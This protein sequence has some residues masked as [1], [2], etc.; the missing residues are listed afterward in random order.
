MLVFQQAGKSDPVAPLLEVNAGEIGFM[1]PP[2]LSIILTRCAEREA[3]PNIIKDLRSEWADARAKVWM[4]VNRLRIAQNVSE[5]QEIRHEL[6]AASRHMSP[7]Q[8][9]NVTRPLRVLWN[10]IAAGAAGAIMEPLTGGHPVFG[11]AKG[12]ITEATKAGAAALYELGPVLFGRGAFD[13]ARRVRQETMSVEYNA[14]TR[15]LTNAEKDKL[16]L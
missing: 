12:A 3:I 15:L 16:R 9:E 14:L 6:S 5:A 1:V 13:L 10:L 2:V 11:A 4:L 8:D 7:S